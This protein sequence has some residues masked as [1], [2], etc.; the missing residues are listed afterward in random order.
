MLDNRTAVAEN[1][2]LMRAVAQLLMVWR[3]IYVSGS[4]DEKLV[5]EFFIHGIDKLAFVMEWIDP[6]WEAHYG[7]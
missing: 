1:D 3:D 4:A 6:D 7:R 2:D 5:A